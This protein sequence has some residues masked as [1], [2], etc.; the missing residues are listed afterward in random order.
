MNV[1]L[2]LWSIGVIIFAVCFSMTTGTSYSD[3]PEFAT[4]SERLVPFPPGQERRRVIISTDIGGS[5]FDDVQSMI[6]VIPYMDKFD[7]E[8]VISSMPAPGNRYWNQIV[9][10]YRRD[11]KNLSF[12]SADYPTPREFK[13]LY[14]LGSTSRF[15]GNSVRGAR[16]II[17]AVKSDD[18][19]PV[20][21]LI[22]GSATDLAIA[23][24]RLRN[25]PQL[26]RKIRPVMIVNGSKPLG[27]NGAGDS[28]AW[29]YVMNFPIKKLALDSMIR[30]MY[31]T[32]FNKGKYGNVRFVRRV[33]RKHGRLGPLFYRMSATINVNRYGIKMGDTPSFFFV[34]NGDWDN[35]G[36]PS[37]GGKF[38][39]KS[40][41]LW[42]GCKSKKIGR[43]PGAGWVARHR[44]DYLKDWEELMKRFDPVPG[45]E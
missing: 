9:R 17:K 29:E 3:K 13:N 25:R 14:T 6:H 8:A 15:P 11:Y 44:I 19:R 43:Y 39:R 34:M 16:Q 35:P 18:P 37:W 5:D 20:Y 22:W 38:C 32:G 12:Y 10:A 2:T 42:V 33:V 27:F 45:I 21:V 31:V 30:G 23:L 4:A 7:L 24:K 41:K 28:G 26:Y 36:K 1:K 40:R